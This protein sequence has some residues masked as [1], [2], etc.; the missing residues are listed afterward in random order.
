MS[1]DKESTELEPRVASLETGNNV[2]RQKTNTD[3]LAIELR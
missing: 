3:L 1:I 2:N